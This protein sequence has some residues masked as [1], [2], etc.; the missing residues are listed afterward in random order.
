M[1]TVT[2]SDFRQN[3]SKYLNDAE[4]NIE[5]IVI[6]RGKGRK[7]VVVS[8]DEYMALQETAYLLSTKKNREHLEKSMKEAK[9]GKVVKAP[10]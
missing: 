3:L 10:F 4:E 8:F 7:S 5:E 2:F 1:T 6:T 9:E